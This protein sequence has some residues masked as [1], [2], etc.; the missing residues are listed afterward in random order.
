MVELNWT[1]EAEQWLHDIYDYISKENPDA[2]L[3]TIESIYKKVQ[4]LKEFPESG[5][6]YNRNHSHHI[7]ILLYGHYRIAYLIKPDRNIDILGVFHGSLDIERYLVE[8]D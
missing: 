3:Q 8:S 4:I 7:R 5:Y 1:H 2:A 6:Y